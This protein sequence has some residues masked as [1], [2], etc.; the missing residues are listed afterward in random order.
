MT[1]PQPPRPSEE[2]TGGPPGE[3]RISLG[4]AV[5]LLVVA[6][7]VGI[8][9]LQVGARPPANPAATTGAT[10]TTTTAPPAT[11][12]TTAP[13]PSTAVKVLVANGG[14]VNGAA[15][16]F[17]AQLSGDG[18]GTLTPVNATPVNA[19]GVYYATGQQ[20]SAGTIAGELGLQPT[21]VHPLATGPPVTGST[22][23]DVLVVVGPDLS[24][25]VNAATGS[26][27]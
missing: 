2:W 22:A 26:T 10:T 4:K 1:A 16:F 13:P 3:D 9:C 24:S 7:V 25:K 20:Q 15:G 11:T 6:V 17:T 5:T 12:T 27:G 21:A 19:S 14:A 8:L 18:W 23:A